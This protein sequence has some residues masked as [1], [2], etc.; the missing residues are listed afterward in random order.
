MST[1]HPLMGMLLTVALVSCQTPPE[2]TVSADDLAKT[3][4]AHAWT[5]LAQTQA[6]L[7][8]ATPIPP[9]ATLVPTVAPPPTPALFP[10]L[11]PPASPTSDTCD[12]P[13]PIAPLGTMVS[14]TLL[15]RSGGTV[16]LAF[17]MTSPN[18]L[19]ECGTYNYSLGVFESP[20]VRVLAGCYWGYGWVTGNKPSTAETPQI[21]C[22]TTAGVEYEVEIGSD[23]IGF[24]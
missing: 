3:A 22:L 7:P 23:V 9:T 11:A 5:E 4:V 17:G 1:K 18:S 15:N 2:P 16:N 14:L 13:P 21:L 24:K 6:A 19:G 8:T 20:T 10:T 12:Q